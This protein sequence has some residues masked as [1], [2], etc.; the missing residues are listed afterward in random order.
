MVSQWSW[1]Q[2]LYLPQISNVGLMNATWKFSLSI[3]D[4][5]SLSSLDKATYSS[6]N[7]PESHVGPSR[8][9]HRKQR[10]FSICPEGRTSKGNAFTEFTTH[11][12]LWFYIKNHFLDSIVEFQVRWVTIPRRK[13]QLDEAKLMAEL[14]CEWWPV[15]NNPM[16]LTL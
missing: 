15:K 5:R 11:W 7:L 14:L 2:H 6:K 3:F 1:R 4:Q 12:P 16:L 13:V 10:S 8:S 9:F